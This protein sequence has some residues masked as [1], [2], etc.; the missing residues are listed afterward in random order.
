MNC[1]NCWKALGLIVWVISSQADKGLSEGSTTRVWNLEQMVKP[2][3]RAT[4]R[5]GDDI[6]WT[7][8]KLQEAKLKRFAVTK[9]DS[10]CPASDMYFIN[11]SHLLLFYHPKRNM[12]MEPFQKPINQQVKV[13]RVLWMGALGSSNNRLHGVLS[14]VTA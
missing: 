12:A 11:E 4:P 2:Q 8:K 10:H 5:S 6:V 3:E 9:S 1:V 13:S 7:C 14:A